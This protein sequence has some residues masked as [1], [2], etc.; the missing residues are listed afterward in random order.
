MLW[1]PETVVFSGAHAVQPSADTPCSSDI[2]PNRG[3][4]VPTLADAPDP[5]ARA[6]LKDDRSRVS[7]G[8]E[9]TG[10][11]N[12]PAPSDGFYY[13]LHP[14]TLLTATCFDGTHSKA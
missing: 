4:G 11:R 12:S 2:Q 7:R 6:R 14:N 3:V 1:Y 5:T 13:R 10:R 9:F 8:E